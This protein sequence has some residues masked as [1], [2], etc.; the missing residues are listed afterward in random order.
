MQLHEAPGTPSF[1]RPII[2]KPRLID[3]INKHH[4]NTVFLARAAHLRAATV[5]AMALEGKAVQPVV[6]MQ[7]L[8]GL[9][10]LTGIT[11]TL[12]DIDMP[13]IPYNNAV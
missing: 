12:S 1:P 5:R 9:E 7:I 2:V 11:Y 13:I 3:L 6:A 10:A 4:I 8:G